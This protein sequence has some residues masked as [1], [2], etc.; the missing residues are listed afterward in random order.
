VGQFHLR[1][2]PSEEARRLSSLRERLQQVSR[3]LTLEN[4]PTD[5][6]WQ[7]LHAELLLQAKGMQADSAE[8]AID[9]ELPDNFSAIQEDMKILRDSARLWSQG[10]KGEF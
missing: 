2:A 6:E 7:S 1:Q 4:W 9:L 5:G 10:T 8:A 3:A